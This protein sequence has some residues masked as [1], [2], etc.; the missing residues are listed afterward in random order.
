MG[1][2]PRG[3]ASPGRRGVGAWGRVGGRALGLACPRSVGR[4]GRSVRIVDRSNQ[5]GMLKVSGTE[6]VL[7]PTASGRSV[8]QPLVKR[9]VPAAA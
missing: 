7:M 9:A 4:S 2:L 3:G 1:R 5:H 8:S 6:T